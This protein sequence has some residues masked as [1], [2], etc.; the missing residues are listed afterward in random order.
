MKLPPNT[1]SD[2]MINAVLM[3]PA[4]SYWLMVAVLARIKRDPVDAL[5]EA[6]TLATLMLQRYNEILIH[7]G[8][9]TYHN[10]DF[11]S[12]DGTGGPKATREQKP[13]FEVL[14]RRTT[15]QILELTNLRKVLNWTPAQLREFAQQTL[16]IRNS[17][18]MTVDEADALLAAMEALR[19]VEDAD[20]ATGRGQV[21]R[22]ALP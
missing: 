17:S 21:N 9:G 14:G 5:S 22:M 11:S 20:L 3:D 19:D 18:T 7:V 8:Y 4:F 1:S 12:P 16:S 15:T 6:Y 10:M 2:D 13:P